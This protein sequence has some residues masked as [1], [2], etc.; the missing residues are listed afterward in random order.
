MLLFVF[1]IPAI[2][3]GVSVIFFYNTPSLN[4]IYSSTLL[5][6]CGINPGFFVA[7]INN[8]IKLMRFREF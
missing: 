7:F 1:A 5:K 3:I 6:F 8:L 4:F 2:V